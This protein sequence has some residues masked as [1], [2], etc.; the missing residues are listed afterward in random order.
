MYEIHVLY[1]DGCVLVVQVYEVQE[2]VLFV[3]WEN[4][5]K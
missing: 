5:R 4:E 3:C 1:T 2:I